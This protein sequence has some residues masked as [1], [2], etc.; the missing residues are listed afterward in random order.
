LQFGHRRAFVIPACH[1]L[2]GLGQP[3]AGFFFA[4]ALA[5]FASQSPLNFS[6]SAARPGFFHRKLSDG[7][8]TV[9]AIRSAEGKRLMYHQ[10][11]D[12]GAFA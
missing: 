12:L 11:I 5:T 6:V 3:L 8:R 9:A 1:L 2:S 10:R 7:E 4:N